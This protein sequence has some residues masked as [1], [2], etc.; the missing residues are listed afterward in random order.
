[1]TITHVATL[2]WIKSLN[3]S[4]IDAW[5][6]W[7]VDDQVAGYTINYAEGEFRLIFASLKGAGHPVSVYSRRESHDLFDRWINDLP[8]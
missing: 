2:K 8:L 4:V 5:R 3:L 6:P 1:M 7:F